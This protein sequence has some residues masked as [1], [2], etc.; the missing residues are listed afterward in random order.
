MPTLTYATRR[1]ELL[2]YFDRT[3]VE[4]WKRLTSD[5]PVNSIRATVRAGRD[6]M[7]RT[8]LGWLPLD[9]R[10]ARILDAG[11]GTGALSVEA[12]R[13]GADVVATD[14]SPTLVALAQERLPPDLSVDFCVGDML[15]PRLGRFDYVVAM[16]SLIHYRPHDTVRV[17]E[18]LASRTDHSLL[19]TFAPRTAA[20]SVMHAVGRLFPRGDRAPAIEPVRPRT[21][22]RLIGMPGWATARTHRVTRGFYI[23]QA[24]EVVRQ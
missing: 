13:R 23:S 10:G 19:F 12:A 6:E 18:D 14:L 4:A 3:A 22:Q 2:R 21:I 17:L 20:L 15:D 24:L 7:R 1:G 11:C 5:A 9:L 16:D 8:L